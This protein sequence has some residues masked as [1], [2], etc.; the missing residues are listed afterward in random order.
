MTLFEISLPE[1]FDEGDKQ[2]SL[3][4]I[5]SSMEQFYAG[6]LSVYDAKK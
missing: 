2:K 5:V 3:K 1:V 6:M 4:E